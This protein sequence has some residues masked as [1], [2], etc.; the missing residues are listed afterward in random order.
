MV[1]HPDIH[2]PPDDQ[3]DV[4]KFAGLADAPVTA[5][6]LPSSAA[7]ALAQAL[8]VKKRSRPGG[9]QVR[10]TSPGNR[11]PN[12]RAAITVTGCPRPGIGRDQAAVHSHPRAAGPC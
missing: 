2:P 7:D 8:G 12:G 9:Q 3:S 11:A 4:D 6:G 1:E 10:P 5:L